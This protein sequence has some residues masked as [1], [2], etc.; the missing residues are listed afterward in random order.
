MEV[1]SINVPSTQ[2]GQLERWKHAIHIHFDINT[3]LKTEI[4]PMSFIRLTCEE[5][6]D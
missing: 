6:S 4:F 3:A 1:N 5:F 2:I